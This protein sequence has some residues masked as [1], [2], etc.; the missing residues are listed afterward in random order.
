M[1][2]RR[3]T[4]SRS[5]MRACC[6]TACRGFRPTRST[7]PIRRRGSATLP[8]PPAAGEAREAEAPRALPSVTAE[9]QADRGLDGRVGAVG[10][11][12][13]QR[14]VQGKRRLRHEFGLRAAMW[15]GGVH[16]ERVAE[17]DRACRAG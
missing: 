13:F 17:I 3:I 5:P 14:F 8:V 10:T 9:R 1:P 11:L 12:E 16:Q 7:R 15:L 4:A 2:A 6:N